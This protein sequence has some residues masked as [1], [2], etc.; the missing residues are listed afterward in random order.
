[1]ANLPPEAIAA[2]LDAVHKAGAKGAAAPTGAD[3]SQQQDPNAQAGADPNADP[4]AQGGGDPNQ[5]AVWA[6][7][8][9]TDPQAAQSIPQGGSPEDLVNWISQFMQQAQQD[10]DTLSQMQEAVMAQVMQMLGGP[11]GQP[12]DQGAAPPQSPGVGGVGAG[13]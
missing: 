10:Q 7:F 6:E 2:A 13:Y 11:G 9:S 1:M 8:P 12:Q 4:N 5:Q 3:P